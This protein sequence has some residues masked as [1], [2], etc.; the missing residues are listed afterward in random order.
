[1]N[2]PVDARNNAPH[3]RYWRNEHTGRDER[4]AIVF[5]HRAPQIVA[6]D[7][8]ARAWHRD[9]RPHHAWRHFYPEG[10]WAA[11]WGISAW[12]MVS[13]VTCEA[14]NE[15]TGEL[16]PVTANRVFSWNDA[17]VNSVLEQ[18]LDECA[19]AAGADVCVPAQPACSFY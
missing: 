6:H 1:M 11:L 5:E 4:H 3:E 7:R 13:G 12:N 10:G 14:A 18:A 17:A 8:W 19:A 9:Y 2:A 15:Q 16:Y